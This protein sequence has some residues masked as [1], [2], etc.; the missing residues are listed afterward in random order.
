M[1]ITAYKCKIFKSKLKAARMFGVLESTLRER[2]ASIIVPRRVPRR[3]QRHLEDSDAT[4]QKALRTDD[5]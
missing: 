4:A 1:T 5:N 2:L 3:L